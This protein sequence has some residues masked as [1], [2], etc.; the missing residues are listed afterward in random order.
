MG[1]GSQANISGLDETA[2]LSGLFC[3]LHHSPTTERL[4]PITCS[5]LVACSPIVVHQQC[6]ASI[7]PSCF[8]KAGE[9]QEKE[10]E[11]EGKDSEGFCHGIL[12]SP[13]FLFSC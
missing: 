1:T 8:P 12:P 13:S 9:D 4:E 3:G 2:A 10:L 5:S 6:Q 7:V 11:E